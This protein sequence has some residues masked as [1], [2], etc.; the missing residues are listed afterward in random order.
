[1]SIG[2]GVGRNSGQGQRANLAYRAI[3]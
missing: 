1:M 2:G 3:Q